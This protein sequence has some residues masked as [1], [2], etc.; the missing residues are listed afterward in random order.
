M[1]TGAMSTKIHNQKYKL[2]PL[3]TKPWK[4]SNTFTNT[5]TLKVSHKL[6]TQ[7]L[8]IPEPQYISHTHT[9]NKLTNSHA[10]ISVNPKNTANLIFQRN[11]FMFLWKSS[12][13]K[14]ERIF[15]LKPPNFCNTIIYKISILICW[16]TTNTFLDR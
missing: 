10:W 16:W 3:L 11:S 2:Q 1:H 8:T 12:L 15:G 13:P 14:W 6:H 7:K 4:Q 5:T 9:I